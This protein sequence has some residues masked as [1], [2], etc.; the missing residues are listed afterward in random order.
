ML[1][2]KAAFRLGFWELIRAGDSAKSGSILLV[3][4]SPPALL[5]DRG[6]LFA[7]HSAVTVTFVAHLTRPYFAISTN[8][9]FCFFG[10]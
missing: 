2:L 7:T 8:F 10:R 4:S 6:I 9:Y 5:T 1:L 3:S